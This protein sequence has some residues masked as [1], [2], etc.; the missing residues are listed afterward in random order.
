MLSETICHKRTA[1]QA[2]RED[3][4]DQD[5]VHHFRRI[6]VVHELPTEDIES[7]NDE[8]FAA[9]EKLVSDLPLVQES[10]KHVYTV[11]CI[12]E[13]PEVVASTNRCH[14]CGTW[15]H[16]RCYLRKF[17]SNSSLS[18]CV[19][20]RLRLSSSRWANFSKRKVHQYTIRCL[21]GFPS[22]EIGTILCHGCDT[23]RHAKC[24]HAD[25]RRLCL[26]CDPRP[27]D[28]TKALKRRKQILGLVIFA[29]GGEEEI[30]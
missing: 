9:T 24:Y 11:K 4:A 10:R 27:F 6:K 29:T 14:K 8:L 25:I 16:T 22:D 18:C 17:G 13:H 12:C 3:P 2:F 26:V 19:D 15:H 7:I 5:Q 1:G 23:W 30:S 28:Y 20:C 21:C